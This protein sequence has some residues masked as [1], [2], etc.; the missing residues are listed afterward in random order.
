MIMVKMRA[1]EVKFGTAALTKLGIQY[2]CRCVKNL[3]L[4]THVE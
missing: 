4:V 1:G 2:M 3:E